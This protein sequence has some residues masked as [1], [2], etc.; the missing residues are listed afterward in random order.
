MVHGRTHY[1]KYYTDK[2]E[3][4]KAYNEAAIEFFGEFAR[5]NPV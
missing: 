1:L 4:A 3:A 5:L 2:I